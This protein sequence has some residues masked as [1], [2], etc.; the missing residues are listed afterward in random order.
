M[1]MLKQMENGND[2]LSMVGVIVASSSSVLLVLTQM[3]SHEW[4][5]P[6]LYVIIHITYALY[7]PSPQWQLYSA[8][9]FFAST[10]YS[11]CYFHDTEL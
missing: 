10:A 5:A 11:S 1:C 9:F 2:I 3:L 8:L 6:L 4:A 7:L